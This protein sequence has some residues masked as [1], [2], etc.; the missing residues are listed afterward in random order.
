MLRRGSAANGFL[1]RDH[2]QKPV[3]KEREYQHGNGD[4]SGDMP[5]TPDYHCQRLLL[6]GSAVPDNLGHQIHL[7]Y[8]EIFTRV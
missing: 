4:H 8:K 7:L 6:V 5:D 1:L 3:V 2:I